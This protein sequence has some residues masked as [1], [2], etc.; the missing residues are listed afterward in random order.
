[1][2]PSGST[3][4]ELITA[5]ANHLY[6]TKNR[7]SVPKEEFIAKVLEREEEQSTCVSEGLMIPHAVLDEGEEITGILGISSKG[8]PLD[9]PDG[10]PVHAIL[11]LATPKAEQKR[12]LEVL[13]AFATT[14]TRDVNL[15]EQ[16]YHARNAAHAYNV[17]HAEEAEDINYFIDDAMERVGVRE[18]KS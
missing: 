14:I 11:L 12:H 5:L 2:D 15:R 7:P 18:D 8:I 13:A 3:K 17:L 10:Q 1:M 16:L 9:A 6:T 4:A